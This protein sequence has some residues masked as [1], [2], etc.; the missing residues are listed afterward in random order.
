MILHQHS[1]LWAEAFRELR[2]VYAHCLGDL[3][4]AIEHVGSTSVPDIKAKPILDIDIV[5]ADYDIFPNQQSRGGSHRS[6]GSA[7]LSHKS[8]LISPNR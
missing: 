7:Q 6:S 1:P 8:N 5:I 2:G 3:A 4:I